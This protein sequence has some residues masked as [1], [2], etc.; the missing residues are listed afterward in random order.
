MTA[1][2]SGRRLTI[3]GT[4]GVLRGGPCLDEGPGG[5]ELWIRDHQTETTEAVPVDSA[6]T[7]GTRATPAATSA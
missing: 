1:F 5:A 3:H 4:K 2:D 7:S 6:D